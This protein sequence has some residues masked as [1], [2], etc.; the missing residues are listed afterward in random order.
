MHRFVRLKGK[1]T[2]LDALFPFFSA[3]LPFCTKLERGNVIPS[4]EERSNSLISQLE[5]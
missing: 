5:S 3:F 2:L 4:L 1:V